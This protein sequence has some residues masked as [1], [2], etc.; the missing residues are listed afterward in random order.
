MIALFGGVAAMNTAMVG[1]STVSTL[2]AADANGPAWSGAPNAVAVLGT[3][4]GAFCAGALVQRRGIRKALLVMYGLALAGALVAFAGVLGSAFV[5]LLAGMALLGLGIGGAQLSR[6]AAAELY[7]ARR[8]GFA[9][10]IIVWAG[11]VGALVGPA[12]LAPAAEFAGWLGLPRLSGPVLVAALLVMGAAGATA[13]MRPAEGATDAVRSPVMSMAAI[14]VAL[15]RRVV[16]APLSAMVAAHVAMVAVM[17]MMPLHLHHHG[18]GLATVGFVLSAHM[19]G[20]FALAP[21]SGRIADRWGARTAIYAGIGTLAVSAAT[22]MAAP[23]AHQSGLP[24][25]L[26]LLG[27]G[28]NL[29]FVGGSSL[30]SREVPPRERAQVQGAADA[31]VWGASAVAS[32]GAGQLFAGGGFVPVVLVAGVL[33]IAPLVSFARLAHRGTKEESERP[34]GQTERGGRHA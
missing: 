9:L 16:A 26:F 4:L 8:K 32:L 6:Y 14:G 12:L 28:W 19:I 25:G 2:I 29:V 18:H 7:P 23:V 17:T 11:T 22:V 5:A 3:A 31:C 34:R 10:S 15:R 21:V 1:A 27:F 30:L 20:M 13:V 24:F 33:A